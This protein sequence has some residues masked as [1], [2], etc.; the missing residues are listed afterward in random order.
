VLGSSLNEVGTLAGSRTQQVSYIGE[1]PGSVA[2]TETV[3]G[4]VY[5]PCTPVDQVLAPP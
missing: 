2:A 4:P 3:T 5:H 1:E